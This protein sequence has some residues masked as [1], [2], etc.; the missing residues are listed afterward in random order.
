M[1][2]EE[3]KQKFI[4]RVENNME[5]KNAE[6]E[7]DKAGTDAMREEFVASINNM[8]NFEQ[9]KITE[10]K[11]RYS[12]YRKY[13]GRNNPVLKFEESEEWQAYEFE[14]V[15]KKFESD[16]QV[17]QDR[18]DEFTMQLEIMADYV[19]SDLTKSLKE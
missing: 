7:V 13:P 18:I 4:D 12:L 5:V 3:A 19:E 14:Q 2:M 8:L 6:G 9:E 10:A 1:N 16:I 11:L 17:C 15:C